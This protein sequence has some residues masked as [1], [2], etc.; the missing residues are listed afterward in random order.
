M[1]V[2]LSNAKDL[3]FHDAGLSKLEKFMARISETVH[4]G[5]ML[6]TI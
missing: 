3:L 1:L 6:L 5:L 4:Q 2:I